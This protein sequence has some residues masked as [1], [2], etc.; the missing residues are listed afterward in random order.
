MTKHDLVWAALAVTLGCGGG[1]GSDDETIGTA[2]IST[3]AATDDSDPD[4]TSD[5]DESGTDGDDDP[6]PS[7]DDDSADGSSSGGSGPV[8]EGLPCGTEFSVSGHSG[9]ETVVDGIGV[10][11]F[12]LPPG[13]HV[14]R[15][16]IYFHG[17]GAFDYMDGWAFSPDIFAWTDPRNTMVVGVLSPAF[18][19]DGT[20]A[21]GAAQPEHAAMV[22]TA[23]ETMLTAWEPTYADQTMYWATS[24]GSWFFASSFIAHVGQRIPGVFVANCGGSGG[25]FGWSWDPMTDA[26]TRDMMPIYFNYGTEDFLAPSIEGSIAEYD[27]LGFE[28]DS[29]VHQGA[30]HCDH[31]IDGP[32]IEFWS[33]YVE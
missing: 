11:F 13:E 7:D 28:V 3:T 4:A 30:M 26:A 15:L 33:R 8:P 2:S 18:Y 9:C 5:P 27:G 29:L 25:S 12:P 10:K 20:V 21:F 17:D 14:E 1:S 16:A 24:G 6:S 19:E 31:P 22:A 23:I 32:T